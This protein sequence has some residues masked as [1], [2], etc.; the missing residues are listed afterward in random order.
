MNIGFRPRLKARPSLYDLVKNRS[1]DSLSVRRHRPSSSLELL[2][3]LPPLPSSPTL[4]PLPTPFQ[5]E[6]PE[7]DPLPVKMPP[8]KVVE[9]DADGEEQYGQYIHS[10]NWGVKLISPTQV[11]FT[12]Y[13]GMPMLSMTSHIIANSAADP[14]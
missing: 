2:R 14:S 6:Q 4:S 11:P 5:P 8:K 9:R 3:E 12:L 1:I 13:L 10:T 7:Q